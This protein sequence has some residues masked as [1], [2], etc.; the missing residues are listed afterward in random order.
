MG[1][2]ETLTLGEHENEY[3]TLIM[4]VNAENPFN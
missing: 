4:T 1:C 3:K 2:L